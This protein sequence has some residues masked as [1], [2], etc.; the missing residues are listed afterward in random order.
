MNQKSE[1]NNPAPAWESPKVVMLTTKSTYNKIGD[2]DE[3]AGLANQPT[4][5]AS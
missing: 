4:F 5:G 3:S 2:P 1:N